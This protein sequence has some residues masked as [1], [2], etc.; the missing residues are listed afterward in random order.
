MLWYMTITA[1]SGDKAYSS[2]IYQ[3]VL[4]VTLPPTVMWGEERSLSY[5]PNKTAE[6]WAPSIQIHV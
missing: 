6:K 2:Y 4:G 1:V 3:R 5:H